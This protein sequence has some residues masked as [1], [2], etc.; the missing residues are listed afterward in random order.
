MSESIRIASTESPGAYRVVR[1]QSCRT[2][3][4]GDLEGNASIAPGEG[5]EFVLR[6]GTPGDVKPS[7]E[8]ASFDCELI[9]DED[10]NRLAVLR[11]EC[12]DPRMEVRVHFSAGPGCRLRKWLTIRNTGDAPFVL[13][14]VVLER[15][16]LSGKGCAWGGGRGWPVFVGGLGYFAVEHPEAENRVSH[17]ECIL[18]YYPAATILPGDSYETERAILEFAASDP[19]EALRQYTDELR[20]RKPDHLLTY[21]C[22]RGAHECEGPSELSVVEQ[23][24]EVA[25]LKSDWHIPFEYFI[26][27]Y[28]YWS[29]DENPVETGRYELDTEA[30]FPGP[31]FDGIVSRLSA[32]K[33]GLGMWF[34]LGC[35]SRDGFAEDLA[36]SILD[37]NSKYGL[38]LVKT[39]YA[40]WSCENSS[41]GHLCGRYARY[42]AAQTMKRVFAQIK[43]ASPEMVIYATSF[44]RSPWWLEYA[45]YVVAGKEDPSDIPAPTIRDSQ[46]LHTDL[47][48]RFFELDAGTYVNFSDANFWC[49][50]QSWRKSAVMSAA[51]SNQLFLAGDLTILDDDDKLFLQRLVQHHDAYAQAFG[52]SRR[53]LGTAAEQQIYGYSNVKDGKGLVAI[54]NP[55]WT[56]DSLDLHALD[57]GCNPEVRNMCIELFPSTQAGSMLEWAGCK[58]R[59]DPWELKMI[60]V[61]PSEEH[62]ALFESRLDHAGKYRMPIT[63]VSLPSD[64][65]SRAVMEAARIC[66]QTGVGFRYR[67]V[68]PREWEGYPILLDLRGLRGELYI[69]NEPTGLH[70]GGYAVYYPGTRDYSRLGFGRQGRYFIALDDP[71]VVSQPEPVIRPLAYSSSSTCREDWPHPRVSGMVLVIRYLKTGKPVR[72]S[73]DPGLAQCSVWLDG[74]WM[75]TWRVPP[76]VPR[77]RSGY[78]WAVYALDLEGDWECARVLIPHLLDADYEI[79]FF[80]TDRIPDIA[81]Q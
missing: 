6:F 2:L 51:R 28:G 16:P 44:S 20:I 33:I 7:L 42:Q 64:V 45:D 43:S 70:G 5:P 40:V 76:L 48:H 52:H 50:K 27:D 11:F 36:R 56:A 13:F 65:P 12:S 62:Y 29:E 74:V 69:G 25:A 81:G 1:R 17:G 8:V 24:N 37:L 53:I 35:P 9:S 55:S 63:P 68:L 26:L 30:K 66:Y 49:G 47:D 19:E 72:P 67:A 73:M 39:D 60:E 78:S 4:M 14:D 23:L 59:F 32:E 10:D 54:F 38:K 15:F 71:G 18:E 46:I 61:A 58:L 41:H 22:T 21:Y 77:I 34:G 80:L 3:E 57:V 75:D 31:S 79:E